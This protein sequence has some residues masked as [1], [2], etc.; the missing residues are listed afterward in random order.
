MYLLE[1]TELDSMSTSRYAVCRVLTLFVKR[2]VAPHLKAYKAL[3]IKN[4]MT[5]K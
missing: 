4:M 1:I 2:Q 5:K 3:V